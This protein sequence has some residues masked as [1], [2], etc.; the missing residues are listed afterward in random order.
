MRWR[1]SHADSA[2]TLAQARAHADSNRTTA[3]QICNPATPLYFPSCLPSSSHVVSIHAAH[4]FH[5]ERH[6]QPRQSQISQ[7][8]QSTPTNFTVGNLLAVAACRGSRA[9][10]ST[11]ANF[12]AGDPRPAPTWCRRWCFN[13]RPPISQRATGI[14]SMDSAADDVSIHARQFHSGRLSR[15]YRA[16]RSGSWFQSTPANFTAGDPQQVSAGT[17]CRCFNPRPP[18]SQRATRLRPSDP[19]CREV[20]IHARQFHSGR[21]TVV[22]HQPD[23]VPVSIHARQFHSGRPA[24]SRPLVGGQQPF[25]STPA[26]FTAGDCCS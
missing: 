12:T 5:S 8:F 23:R 1:R 18:I 7:A 25:Q 2:V 26:N 15:P 3:I 21:R 13:P 11:P 17:G 19:A 20:S 22:R 9:F 24:N 6:T 10:Q 4:Q 14:R 16:T